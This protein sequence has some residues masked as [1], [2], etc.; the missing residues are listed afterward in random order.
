MKKLIFV[1]L[2]IFLFFTISLNQK[3]YAQQSKDYNLSENDVSSLF[4]PFEE[5]K[6]N[7]EW[8]T[9][10]GSY[11]HEGSDLYAQDWNMGNQNDDCNEKIN[12]PILGKIIYLG[13]NAK[14]LS[15]DENGNPKWNPNYGQNVIILSPNE[16]FALRIAHLKKNSTKNL[17]VGDT[18]TAGSYIGKVSNTGLLDQQTCHA[19]ISLH[20]KINSEAIQRMKNNGQQPGGIETAAEFNFDGNVYTDSCPENLYKAEYFNN[21]NFSNVVLSHCTNDIK[22]NWGKKNPHKLVNNDNFSARFSG[23][24]LFRN[25]DYTL[26]LE[27]DEALK[28]W[29]NG[30]LIFDKGKVNKIQKIKR[31]FY[32]DIYDIKFEYKE[33]TKN[34][35]FILT[36][37]LTKYYNSAPKINPVP[38]QTANVG[39]DFQDINLAAYLVDPD[40]FDSHQWKVHKNNQLKASLINKNILRVQAAGNWLGS[41]ELRVTVSDDQNKKASQLIKFTRVNNCDYIVKPSDTNDLK[42]ALRESDYNVICLAPKSTY[43]INSVDNV[44][45][46]GANGLPKLIGTKVIQGRNAR[47]IRANNA[48]KFR[49][50]TTD[51]LETQIEFY[52]LTFENGWATGD[53]GGGVIYNGKYFLAKNVKFLNN[54]SDHNGGAIDGYPYSIADIIDSHFISNNALNDSDGGAIHTGGDGNYR[55]TNS[56]FINNFASNNGGAITNR[57]YLQLKDSRFESNGANHNGGAIMNQ[58]NRSEID[59]TVIFNNVA[60]LQ[61]S[62]GGAIFNNILSTVIVR[63]ASIRS[64]EADESGAI[65]NL[66]QLQ[67]NNTCIESNKTRDSSKYTVTTETNYIVDVLFNWWEHPLGPGGLGGVIQNQQ[68]VG[69]N[70]NYNP[71]IRERIS[72]CYL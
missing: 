72:S 56:T 61:G 52:D 51:I 15:I 23:K 12:S 67:V 18:V 11:L 1:G 71:F 37:K 57:G 24:I 53:Y 39:E 30:E 2:F 58:W 42:K 32:N 40:N 29:I 19:H 8:H 14:Y 49:F 10:P 4:W 64:N 13:F 55:V 70:I 5:P 17:K 21:V 38:E 46:A 59:N 43:I 41:Q 66:E 69:P 25:A 50:F 31:R 35:F 9:V 47:I 33:F 3:A 28:F 63:N 7:K 34:A 6:K 65:H 68:K 16:K 62:Q 20:K 27:Y 54:K 36:P 26:K 44:D 45:Y 22:N 48:P 60:L